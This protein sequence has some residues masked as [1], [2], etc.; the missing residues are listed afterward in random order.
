MYLVKRRKESVDHGV[1]QTFGGCK[2]LARGL[3]LSLE[4]LIQA[5]EA[6]QH[7]VYAHLKGVLEKRY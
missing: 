5:F 7:R 4:Y 1:R 3:V 2:V 6:Y